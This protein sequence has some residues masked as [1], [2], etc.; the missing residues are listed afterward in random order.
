MK[1][2][3]LLLLSVSCFG[4]FNPM[5]W[6]EFGNTNTEVNTFIGGVSGTINTPSLL[7]AKLGINVGRIKKF[8]VDGSDI[9]CAIING[10]YSGVLNAFNGV[11]A[12][13]IYI[14]SDGLIINGTDGF[15]QNSVG[16]DSVYMP[17]LESFTN[18]FL[19]SESIR[20]VHLPKLKYAYAQF[21]SIQQCDVLETINLPELLQ[22]T[23]N[24]EVCRLNPILTLVNIPKCTLIG[25]TQGRDGNTFTGSNLPN[26]TIYANT[27]LQTSNSGGVEGDLA[28]AI[29]GGAT[30]VWVT[31]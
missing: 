1:K 2:Y 4:Q 19:N 16:L 12:L 18:W 20:H 13:T 25:N 7:A 30:V 14:D 10:N 21:G 28:F 24:G 3:I 15:L 11:S 5:Q 31:P 29:A 6:Y 17:N 9:Q 27:F 26:L 8:S 22:W 23:G